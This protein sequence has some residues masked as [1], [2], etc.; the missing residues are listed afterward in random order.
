MRRVQS[1]A[2][3]LR[4]PRSS[5]SLAELSQVS[6]NSFSVT[7]LNTNP[8]TLAP[9]ERFYALSGIRDAAKTVQF[10]NED[11]SE[12]G[13]AGDS[14]EEG[15]EVE[16]D[17]G[18]ELNGDVLDSSS[19]SSVGSKKQ[20]LDKKTKPHF[21]L[22]LLWG[23][24]SYVPDAEVFLEQ[25]LKKAIKDT[26]EMN[27]SSIDLDDDADFRSSFDLSA[28][29]NKGTL[30]RNHK[31]FACLSQSDSAIPMEI[32]FDST[33]S[34][35]TATTVGTSS[36]P[37][38]GSGQSESQQQQKKKKATLKK[39]AL[40]VYLVIDRVAR[41]S[42]EDADEDDDYGGEYPSQTETSECERLGRLITSNRPL[43]NALEGLT[44]GLAV[45][46]SES[47]RGRFIPG[48]EV[49]MQ[50]FQVGAAE[51]KK[52]A[53]SPINWFRRKG[54]YA[55][56]DPNKTEM[57]LVC[58]TAADLLGIDSHCGTSTNVNGNSDNGGSAE[59][60]MVSG[61]FRALTVGEWRHNG[62]LL[63]FAERSMDDWRCHHGMET[64]EEAM[65]RS[66]LQC[67]ERKRFRKKLMQRLGLDKQRVH[68]LMTATEGTMEANDLANIFVI[69]AIVALA[70]HL[71]NQ[72]RE[73][74]LA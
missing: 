74:L 16:T 56:G 40:S 3:C 34:T 57:T 33:G 8:C 65:T 43:R 73:Q 63:S 2:S 64:C 28:A 71:W 37:A 19:S 52:Y 61:G 24:E 5:L 50:A 54:R 11:D 62:N 20:K 59:P 48:L 13:A 1:S 72:Y 69:F 17:E 49:A 18:D 70:A 45:S 53:S 58:Q 39:K 41:F 55:K 36:T 42:D 27:G 47:S 10:L 32:G 35:A 9:M 44:I 31:S 67:I 66:Q 4:R 22:Y 21:I 23:N 7:V 51:R 60:D 25:T 12:N 38:G 68:A 29:S 26:Y 46:P 6:A 30:K 14:E 15:L